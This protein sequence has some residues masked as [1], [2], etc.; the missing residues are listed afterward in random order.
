MLLKAAGK[1]LWLT[2]LTN[3]FPIFWSFCRARCSALTLTQFCGLHW[4]CA[5]SSMF[6]YSQG[7]SGKDH[8]KKRS[9]WKKMSL[10][11]TASMYGCKLWRVLIRA[12]CM[13][14]AYVRGSRLTPNMH[15]S[16]ESFACLFISC[17]GNG[18]CVFRI[19][20]LCA[21]CMYYIVHS[22]ILVVEGPA[23]SH[24]LA[25]SV[26]GV[27]MYWWLCRMG[28]A[29][30]LTKSRGPEQTTT[31]TGCLFILCCHNPDSTDRI[32]QLHYTNDQD[33]WSESMKIRSD[34]SY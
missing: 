23:W 22:R 31:T 14:H 15:D 30:L 19:V 25:Y 13:A 12:A 3:L 5:G 20:K 33:Q 9:Q 32:C 18:D 27:V 11:P 8:Q 34:R 26:E 4:A 29:W 6:G 28:N 24:C 1:L 7:P 2:Y 16:T 17:P 21:L 10:S